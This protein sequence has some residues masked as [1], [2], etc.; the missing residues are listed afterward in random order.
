MAPSDSDRSP[1]FVEKNQVKSKGL[2]ILHHH[3]AI[4]AE[5]GDE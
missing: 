3:C 4:I 2:L 1:I 5:G